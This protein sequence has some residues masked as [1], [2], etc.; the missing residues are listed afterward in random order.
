[1]PRCALRTI[2]ER[3]R[4]DRD[5]DVS[6]RPKMTAMDPEGATL[7]REAMIFGREGE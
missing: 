7:G 5:P 1:V 4:F 3:R 6:T 2:R